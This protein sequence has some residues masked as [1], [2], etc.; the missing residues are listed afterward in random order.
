MPAG[1]EHRPVARGEV[2][3]LL[4]EPTGTPNTGDKAT[5]A[6]CVRMFTTASTSFGACL[7]TMCAF[8]EKR[9]KYL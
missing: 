7:A 6:P 3:I 4:I 5:A 8:R 1:V 9:P 2:H